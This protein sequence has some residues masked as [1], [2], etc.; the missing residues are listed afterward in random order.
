MFELALVAV[1]IFETAS[2]L[3]TTYQLLRSRS[4]PA[5][6]ITFS[7]FGLIGVVVGAWTGRSFEWQTSSGVRVLGFPFALAVFVFENGRWIDYVQ[8]SPTILFLL[9]VNVLFPVSIALAPVG[10]TSLVLSRRTAQRDSH[11]LH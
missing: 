8:P 10:V 2:I 7:F 9:V 6:W 1:L 11:K 4:G 3:G 5:T